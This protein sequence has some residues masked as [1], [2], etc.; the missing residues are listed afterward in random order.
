M[1]KFLSVCSLVSILLL[2]ACASQPADEGTSVDSTMP[3]IDSDVDEMMVEDDEEEA[4]MNS[5]DAM[6]PSSSAMMKKEDGAMMRS[7]TKV[8]TVTATNFAFTPN[9]IRVKKGEKVQLNFASAEGSHGV[10]IKDLG[11]NVSFAAGQTKSID[12]PTDQTGTFAFKCSVPC[13]SG[14]KD[15]IGTIVVE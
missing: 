15:M 6:M 9:M 11:I 13:G 7:E 5:D 10:A 14:H 1:K 3:A 2:S 8:V 4:M 12:L